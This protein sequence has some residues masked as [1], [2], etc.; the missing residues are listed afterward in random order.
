MKTTSENQTPNVQ[1][2]F[3]CALG[4]EGREKRNTEKSALIINL[5]NEIIKLLRAMRVRVCAY[6]AAGSAVPLKNGSHRVRNTRVC[7]A[8]ERTF[9]TKRIVSPSLGPKIHLDR[10]TF[11]PTVKR[12]YRFGGYGLAH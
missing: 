8:R 9:G 10:R 11:V 12:H 2:K 7:N 3:K 1:Y 5:N 6:M 4:I